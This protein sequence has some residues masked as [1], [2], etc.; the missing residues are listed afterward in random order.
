[1]RRY[2]EELTIMD[3]ITQVQKTTDQSKQTNPAGQLAQRR[4]ATQTP[5][6]KLPTRNT[7]ARNRETFD[8]IQIE[9]VRKNPIA[10][11]SIRVAAKAL[12]R[13][14]LSAIPTA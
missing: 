11:W 8:S 3:A 5:I 1:M 14:Q 6:G 13:K 10:V 7:I 9:I 12:E 4:G 2:E